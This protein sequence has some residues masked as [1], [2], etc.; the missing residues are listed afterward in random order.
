MALK[1]ES[2]SKKQAQGKR[3]PLDLAK[4]FKILTPK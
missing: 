2:F 3:N 4:Q 1:F